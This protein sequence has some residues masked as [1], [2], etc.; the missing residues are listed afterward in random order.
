[1]KRR[2]FLKVAATLP[3]LS[4]LP[5][6]SE[7]APGSPDRIVV[8]VKLGGGNDGLNMVVPYQDPQYYR[9]RPTIAVPRHLALPLEQN[10]ALNPYMKALMPFWKAGEIAWIQ[11]IGYPNTDLSHFRSLDIWETASAQYRSEGWLNNILPRF[12]QGLHG[13][14]LDENAGPFCGKDCNAITMQS[15]EVFLSQVSLIQDIRPNAT[16]PALRH[17]TQVQHQ[18]YAAGEQLRTKMSRP[19]GLNVP[20]ST[21]VF[22]RRLESVAKMIINGV[23]AVAY[24][25]E[26]DGFDTH[27]N[28]VDT[29]SNLLQHLSVGLSSFANAMKAAGKWDNVLVVTYSEFGRRVQENYGRGTDHGAGS[30]HLVMGGRVRGGLHGDR[31]RLNELDH[32]MNLA[33]PIDFRKLYGTI[34][35]NWWRQRNPWAGL[36]VLPI[37]S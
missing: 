20:F 11:G 34:T 25:V 6:T 26:L 8:F 1:M 10:M 36:G 32:N 14:I 24:K 35:Q 9:L 13:I 16:S 2:D 21:S 22:G 27:V 15:P 33:S 5:L 29:Q 17:I 30:T 31:P 4:L 18:L 12:K 19:Q 3:T 28:Q 37:L 7:A 23:D